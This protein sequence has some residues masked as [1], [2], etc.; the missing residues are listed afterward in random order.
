MK[1]FGYG[2]FREQSTQEGMEWGRCAMVKSGGPRG[3]D[4]GG[5]KLGRRKGADRCQ[6]EVQRDREGHDS[7]DGKR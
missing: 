6:I 2:S 7:D 4:E 5:E 3:E 1:T